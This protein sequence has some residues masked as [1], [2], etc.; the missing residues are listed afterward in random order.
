MSELPLVE[1]VLK[2]FKENNLSFCMPGHKNGKGFLNTSVGKELYN[3]II[4]MDLT[5]VEGMDNLHHPEGIINASQKLLSKFYGSKKSYFLVNGSTSGN[6]AMIFSSFNEGDKVIVERNCH[7]SIFNGI[8]LRKLNPIYI[9]SQI[10][11]EYEAP[12]SIDMEHFLM[13]I[14]QNNDAKGII[15][16]YPTY[17]GTCF[18]LR[19]IIKE[20]KKYNMKVLVDSAHGAHFGVSDKLPKSALKLGA[21]MVVM[22]AHKTL[23]AFTQASY[24][25]IGEAVETEKVDFYVSTFLST[26]PSYMLMCSLDYAR[27]YLEEYGEREYEKLIEIADRYRNKI[28]QI[29]Y[30]HVLERNES[31]KYCGNVSLNRFYDVDSSRYILNLNSGLSGHKLLSYLRKNK[32]QCEMSD[33]RNVILIFS[34]FNDEEQFKALYEALKNCDINGLKDSEAIKNNLSLYNTKLPESRILP[35]KVLESKTK[36][37]VIDEA[38]GEIC[39]E[40]II[41]YPPGVPLIMPGEVFNKGVIKKIRYCI[42]NRITLLGVNNYEIKVV[43]I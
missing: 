13:Q 9:N 41:P 30:L 31:G 18:D 21:D 5:E 4:G 35:Y 8:L 27:Y 43:I 1:G 19:I 16:T 12:L 28:N 37:A 32:I 24:L 34:P 11:S 20:A 40:A 36:K 3:N 6:M 22:S 17:Y 33:G 38:E 29:S 39:A 23:P 15:V 10:D 14:R 42:K 25:H 2:Y 7:R 26:S